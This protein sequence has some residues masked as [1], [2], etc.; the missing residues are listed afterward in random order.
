MKKSIISSSSLKQAK[1]TQK[2]LLKTLSSTDL[3]WKRTTSLFVELFSHKKKK[4]GHL[5][6]TQPLHLKKQNVVAYLIYI[7]WSID[8]L[9][10]LIINHHVY[11]PCLLASINLRKSCLIQKIEAEIK[12]H[13]KVWKWIYKAD[14]ISHL[15]Q[16]SAFFNT[17]QPQ[18]NAL[19]FFS[20][21]CVRKW[22]LKFKE[23]N[24]SQDGKARSGSNLYYC[25][26]MWIVRSQIPRKECVKLE[27]EFDWR[28]WLPYVR[29]IC[30]LLP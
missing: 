17:C 11:T 24:R 10:R 28:G 7:M 2:R 26:Y 16:Q 21:V 19:C 6:K 18:P 12:F 1:N 5:I 27:A 22:E 29:V 15:E 9:T 14:P 30:L 25:M 13:K 20:C 8:P 3:S 23:L 4:S